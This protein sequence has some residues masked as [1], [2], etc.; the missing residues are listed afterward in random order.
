MVATVVMLMRAWAFEQDFPLRLNADTLTTGLLI[1]LY[2]IVIGCV[3]MLLVCIPLTLILSALGVERSSIYSVFGFL[4]GCAVALLFSDRP[5]HL[6]DW[7]NVATIGGLPG[8][9]A[10]Q[11]WWVSYRRRFRFD[12]HA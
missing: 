3:A 12:Q 10:G 4:T 8:A 1:F 2:C 7:I 11:T 6:S 9:I 5:L